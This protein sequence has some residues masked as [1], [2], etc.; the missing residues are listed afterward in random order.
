[1]AIKKIAAILGLVLAVV[2][3]ASL[4]GCA[5]LQ[6]MQGIQGPEGPQGP[7]GPE[8]VQGPQGPEG[9][10]GPQGPEGPQG[11][12]GPTR[13]IVV[14]WDPEE[15]EAYGYFGAVEAKRSQ[16]VRIKGAGF[17]PDDNVTL[18]IGVNGDDVVLG[19]KVTVNDDGAFEVSRTI[20]KNAPY[21]P[22]SV[23]AWLD[24]T[25]SGDEVTKGDFQACW[26]LDIVKSLKSF[27]SQ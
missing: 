18:T 16:T 3:M 15:F 27:P 2:L 21:A 17:D 11:P 12:A 10:Q 6:G 4:A 5:G 1:M 19:K 25:V 8:G 22:T 9:V 13:Q 14:T 7:R 23:K 24:A 26:P 20:P